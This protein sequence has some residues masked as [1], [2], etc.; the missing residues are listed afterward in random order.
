[1]GPVKVDWQIPVEPWKSIAALFLL[2]KCD[3]GCTFCASDLGFDRMSFEQACALIDSL[4]EAGY[5]NIVLGGGEPALWRDGK[6]SLA[7]LAAHAKSLGLTVQVNTNGIR[8]AEGFAN[9][10]DV[11]RFIFP[12]DGATS[13]MHDSLRIVLGSKPTGHFDLVQERVRQC[14]EAG[15]Q[16][17][18]GTVLNRNN[19][20][21]IP[22]LVEWMRRQLDAGANVHAWHL[23]RF[24][25]VGR[26]GVD[27]GEQL[28]LTDEQFRKACAEAKGAGLP[29]KI[30]RRDDM[31]NSSTVEFFWF[32]G[33]KLH[34]GGQ[35]WGASE[36]S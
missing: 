16:I 24:Q 30:W 5:E 20:E 34:V 27:S 33:G 29:I 19:R 22:A 15:K 7:D 28:A 23:Y 2:P 12:M 26:G 11:D 10:P 4:H 14:T 21:D 36:A 31:L 8:L 18:I 9:I 3:M 13:T 32:D 17:S 6:R 25:A 35:V 1:M